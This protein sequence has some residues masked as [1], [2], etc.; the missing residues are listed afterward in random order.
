MNFIR[1]FIARIKLGLLH[2]RNCKTN[3]QIDLLLEYIIRNNLKPLSISK[4][5][6]KFKN[7]NMWDANKYYAWLSSGNSNINGYEFSWDDEMASPYMMLKFKNYLENI[8]FN[9]LK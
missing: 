8:M 1:N 3:E 7:C 2:G 5:S 9:N 6:I 4:Y